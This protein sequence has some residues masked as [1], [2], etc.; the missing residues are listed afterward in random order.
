MAIVAG[1]DEAG[2]G[3]ML[4]PLVVSGVAFRVPD[5]RVDGCLWK[6]LRSS[7]TRKNTKNN[8]R[9]V[10]ADSKQLYHCREDLH[11]LERPV[12]VLLGA[13]GKTP[14][15]WRGLLDEVSPE[16]APQLDGYP[17]YS[18][19]DFP[20]PAG[21]GV[22][23]LPTRTNAVRSDLADNQI[24]LAGIFCDPM[25][26]AHFNGLVEKIGNKSLLVMGRVFRLV[27]RIINCCTG[28]QVRICVDH[29]GGRVRYREPLQT[30][31]PHFALE[32]IEETPDRSAYRLRDKTRTCD[33]EFKVKGEQDSFAVALASMC[34]K[35]IREL[36]MRSFNDYWC[37]Q[38]DG[39]KPTAGYYTDA[40]RWL[41]DAAPAL[42]RLSIDRKTLVRS[43]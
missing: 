13:G 30:A 34:S 8:Q 32:I 10:I 22:G 27:D 9:L 42:K 11:Q 6:T 19:S 3:P 36:Y 17:W 15:T 43:R 2:F 18:V 37:G 5:D 39:L 35:Y 12:L 41:E 33:I 40:Q 31:F 24:E 16:A 4:G 14:R 26:E 7:C 20:I 21:E 25:P 23:D 38:H 28:G 1:I 29:L